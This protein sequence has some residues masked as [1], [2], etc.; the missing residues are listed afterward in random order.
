MRK[1]KNIALIIASLSMTL[2]MTAIA[3]LYT[4]PTN[5]EVIYLIIGFILSGMLNLLAIIDHAHLTKKEKYD[6]K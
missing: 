3:G 5:D 1:Q 4:A 6:N 2:M